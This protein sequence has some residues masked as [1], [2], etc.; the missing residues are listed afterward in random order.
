[1]HLDHVIIAAST[2]P[3]ETPRLVAEYGLE[4]SVGGEHPGW[5]TCNW[6]VALGDAYLELVAVVDER[7]ARASSFGSRALESAGG[8]LIGWAVR[9]DDLDATAGRLGLDVGEGSRTRPSGERVEWR[10]AG[11]DEAMKRPW[12]PFFI[13][14]RDHAAFPGA[15]RSPSARIVRLE[16]EC[17]ARELSDWLGP[18]SIPVDVRAGDAG[19][20]AVVLDGPQGTIALGR[21]RA[22]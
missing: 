18:H 3:S 5:G 10:M 2:R 19:L 12:L 15:T 6:L 13:A 4:L 20:T 1:M 16:L 7:V 8:G 11:L 21:P 14:W 9:P 17:D 22:S